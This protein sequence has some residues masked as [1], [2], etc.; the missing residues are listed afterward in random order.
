MFKEMEPVYVSDDGKE[1]FKEYYIATSSI[2]NICVA[3]TELDG[4]IQTE[5]LLK[6]SLWKMIKKIPSDFKDN[7][8]VWVRDKCYENFILR[9]F[10]SYNPDGSVECYMNG[11]T[12]YT[13]TNERTTNWE[14]CKP[15]EGE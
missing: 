7:D 14:E 1:W 11:K 15:Y 5:I 3:D 4:I 2:G 6:M 12:K 9:Y 10:K 13:S 8:L